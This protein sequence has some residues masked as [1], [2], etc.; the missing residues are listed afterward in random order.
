MFSNLL[1]LSNL[2]AL[3]TLTANWGN[4]PL[5]HGALIMTHFVEMSQGVPYGVECA[6]SEQS[7]R[8]LAVLPYHTCQ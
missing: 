1:F 6:A 3:F 7:W 2:M 5:S 4:F 8:Q